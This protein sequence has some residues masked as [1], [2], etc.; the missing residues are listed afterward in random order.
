MAKRLRIDLDGIVVSLEVRGYQPP[1]HDDW[2]V[3]WCKVDFSFCSGEWLN[4]H[5]ENDEVLLSCEVKTLAENIQ[6]LLNDELKE[7][8]EISCIEP[9]FG[10]VLQPKRDLREDPK[11]VYIR[12]GLEIAD[13]YMEWVVSFW[14]D[15]LTCNY[16]S[17]T[18][19]R[20]D[21]TILL[22]YLNYVIGKLGDDDPS[23][24]QLMQQG[25]IV[26]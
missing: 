14:N 8:T 22:A 13:V 26:D 18:L 17:V 21:L 4:Y 9:D 5:K 7:E 10:F 19:D 2:D 12:E 23:I 20:K 16:L 24:A 3:Q 1:S 15:G 11:Y 25:L 6:Q